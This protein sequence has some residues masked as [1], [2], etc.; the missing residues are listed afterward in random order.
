MSLFSSLLQFFLF[1]TMIKTK[2][3]RIGCH[4]H[5]LNVCHGNQIMVAMVTTADAHHHE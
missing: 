4:D 1:E 3:E 5:L 2:L